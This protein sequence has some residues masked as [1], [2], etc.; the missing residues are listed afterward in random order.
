MP[1]LAHIVLLAV[2][3]HA[4]PT[5]LAAALEAIRRLDTI[6]GVAAVAAGRDVSIDGL[7]A[8]FTHGV[9]VEFADEAAR[10]R[11]GP[12]PAHRAVLTK[13]EPLIDRKL[14]LDIEKP[15]AVSSAWGNGHPQMSVQSTKEKR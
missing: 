12:H 7:A 15:S 4:E 8:D 2:K 1:E 6:E 10:A 13:L 3:E 5:E 14:I 11:Y 9:V